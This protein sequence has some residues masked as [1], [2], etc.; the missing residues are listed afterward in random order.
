VPQLSPLEI[1]VVAAVALIV[2]G[3]EKLPDI[4]RTV[5]GAAARMRRMAAEFKEEFE[6]SVQVGDDEGWESVDEPPT[7]KR[8][9]APPGPAGARRSSR[10]PSAR[11]HSAEEPAAEPQDVGPDEREEVPHT[12][13]AP[14]PDPVAEGDAGDPADRSAR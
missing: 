4:A 13:P 10:S 3:P 11:P 2:F 9:P 8:R 1:L 6:T 7:P 14:K 12:P 5:G